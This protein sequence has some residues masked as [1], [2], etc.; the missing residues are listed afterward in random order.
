MFCLRALTANRHART[1]APPPFRRVRMP[2]PTVSPTCGLTIK[3]ALS[4]TETTT[5]ALSLTMP[6]AL[7]SYEPTMR[8]GN[9]TCFG[10]DSLLALRLSGP[11]LRHFQVSEKNTPRFILAGRYSKPDRK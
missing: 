8:C 7:F 10:Q 2:T 5:L 1:L 9:D 6:H 3:P 4:E 11:S